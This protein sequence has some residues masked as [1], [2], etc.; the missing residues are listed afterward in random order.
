MRALLMMP[1]AAACLSLACSG[2]DPRAPSA[3][4]GPSAV[5]RGADLPISGRCDGTY[6]IIP[7][8]YL[9]PPLD[10]FAAHGRGLYR[11]R[12]EI[13]HLGRSSLTGEDLIDFTTDPFVAA[14]SRQFASANGDILRATVEIFVPAPGRQQDV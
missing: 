5:V 9:P 13:T 7:I 10:E 4:V 8:D 1:L 2:D 11:G 12:C 6:D 14:G 3:I